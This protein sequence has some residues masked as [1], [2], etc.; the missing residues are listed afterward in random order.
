MTSSVFLMSSMFLE[1]G[2]EVAVDAAALDI[3]H[4]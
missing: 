4:Q 2:L 3:E 1:L